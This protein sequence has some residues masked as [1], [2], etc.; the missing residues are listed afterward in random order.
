LF[1]VAPDWVSGCSWNLAQSPHSG[2]IHI[3]LGDGSVRFV[4]AGIT[5][6][7]WANLC[8]PCD[9]NMLGNDW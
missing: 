2:G 7:T 1:Q 4:G 6:N 3:G 8:N 5:A 9:G